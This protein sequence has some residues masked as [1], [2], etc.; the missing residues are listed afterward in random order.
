MDSRLSRHS[1]N[2]R[3]EATRCGGLKTRRRS[4]N[5]ADKIGS[6]SYSKEVVNE[7]LL[8][9]TQLGART[10]SH[11]PYVAHRKRLNSL[12]PEGRRR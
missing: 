1:F 8:P 9:C 3:E 2:N 5:E 11:R 12:P 7:C 6:Y 10:C 4:I